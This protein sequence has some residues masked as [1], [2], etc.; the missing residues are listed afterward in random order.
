MNIQNNSDVILAAFHSEISAKESDFKHRAATQIMNKTLLPYN[1]CKIE[2][3]NQYL[4]SYQREEFKRL[5]SFVS[6]LELRL[7]RASTLSAKKRITKKITRI[8]E[9]FKTTDL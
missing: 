1:M 3:E 5:R 4:N 9:H 2:L 6:R 8:Y 7:E